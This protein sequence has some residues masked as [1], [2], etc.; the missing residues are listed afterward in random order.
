MV[1]EDVAN[2]GFVPSVVGVVISPAARLNTFY[3]Y[4]NIL[5]FFSGQKSHHTIGYSWQKA[6]LK[7]YLY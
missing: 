2:F 6:L 1:I 4:S 5:N 3:L 7:R